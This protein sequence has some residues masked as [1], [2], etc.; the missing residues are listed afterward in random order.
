M[1][2]SYDDLSSDIDENRLLLAACERL[3]R[4]RRL[5]QRTTQTLRRVVRRLP[6]VQK[7]RYTKNNLPNIQITRLNSRYESALDL[8]KLILSNKTIELGSRSIRAEGMLFDMANVFEDFVHAALKE[9]LKLRDKN[10]PSQ[11]AVSLDQANIVKLYPDFS[12]WEN[13]ICQAVG[14]V[15]YKKDLG[16]ER[17]G[18]N[19]DIY[20]LLAYT[21][22]TQLKEGILVYADT[23][24]NPSTKSHKIKYANKLLHIETLNLQGS[25]KEIIARVNELAEKIKSAR[26]KNQLPLELAS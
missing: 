21:T 5:D 25:S 22:A 18:K 2:V 13:D 11:K 7:V 26:G 16:Q 3:L 10:F 19:A 8:A 20:Q 9:S 12:W 24:D 4:L 6:E 15:K 23:E 1:E 14:D 17:K